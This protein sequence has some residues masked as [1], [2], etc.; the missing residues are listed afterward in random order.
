MKKNN[1]AI[2]LLLLV[3]ACS[4]FYS[5]KKD[6]TDPVNSFCLP[7]GIS[8]SYSGAL[9][10]PEGT[11]T[12]FSVTKQ[13]C[14]VLRVDYTAVDVNTGNTTTRSLTVDN[15]TASTSNNFAGRYNGEA[16]AVSFT[17]GNHISISKDGST[18][19][20]FNGNK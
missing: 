18:S 1:Y 19:F 14:Q 16:V 13:S 4:I 10:A 2:L 5:C 7:D 17:D 11:G 12:Q 20:S 15:F 6:N 3:M 8:G 9:S